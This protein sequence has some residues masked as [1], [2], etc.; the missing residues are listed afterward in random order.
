M[1][2]RTIEGQ[3]SRPTS[4]LITMIEKAAT[5]AEWQ[6]VEPFR[7]LGRSALLQRGRSRLAVIVPRREVQPGLIEEQAARLRANS[8]RGLWLVPPALPSQAIER[9]ETPI[10]TLLDGTVATPAHG[11]APIPEFI[12]GT[13]NGRLKWAS[14]PC[15]SVYGLWMASTECPSCKARQDY[16]AGALWLRGA[17]Y[18]Q[19]RLS[20][21]PSVP[22][23]PLDPDGIDDVRAVMATLPRPAALSRDHLGIAAHCSKCGCVLPQLKASACTGDLHVTAVGAPIIERGWWT[24]DGWPR[25]AVV[26]Q[27]STGEKRNYAGYAVRLN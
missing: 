24:W 15:P 27:L 14:A 11:R 10:F 21:P 6:P 23:L 8:A 16:P 20:C 22:L 25:P 26:S 12:Q 4:P 7:W 3:Q 18:D 1:Q 19:K 9:H 17:V 13:L 5:L 2:L